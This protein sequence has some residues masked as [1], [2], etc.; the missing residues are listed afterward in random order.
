MCSFTVLR[1]SRGSEN[2]SVSGVTTICLMQCNTSPSH[3]VDQVVDCSLWNVGPLLFNG[4][5][6]LLDIGRNWNTLSCTPIQS[7]P[8]MLNGW[9]VRWV[10]WPCKNWDVFSF[11]KLYTDPCNM[12]PCII[13]LQHE[14]MVVDEWHNNG[15]QDL[16]TVSLCIQNA[17]NKM[18]LCSLSIT[19][20]CPYHNP[21]AT[22]GHSIHNVDFSKPLTHTRCLPSALYIE[23]RDSSV[24]RT[25]LQS[26]R[27]HRMW[28]FAH[29]SRL[30]RRTAVRSRPRWGRQACRWASLRRFLTVCAEILWLCKPIVAAAVR[31]AGLRRSWRW[32][33]WMWRSWASVVTRGLQLWGRLDVLPNYLKRL[34]RRLMVEKLTFNSRA[35]ALVDIPAVSMPIA[36]SLK[37]C[38][39]CGIVLCDKTAHYRVAFYCGQPKAHL[40]NNHAVQSASWYATP[41]RWMDYLGKGE[42]LTNTDLDRFVNNIWEK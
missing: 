26:A 17:I 13:M 11:Q 40:Y 21:S 9:H 23:N 15:P 33:C 16:V 7:I 19:Y 3:R 35:T 2:Q 4:C 37:T 10:C 29:L 8:N 30:R 42:V 27:C 41:V 18:H 25:P 1:G 12:G 31:V 38:D 32:R 5:A 36:R 34:W 22:M 6:K 20:A 14:V 24:K 28:A 39:I